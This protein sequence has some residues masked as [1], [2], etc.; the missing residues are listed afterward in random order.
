MKLP[1]QVPGCVS[2]MLQQGSP[3]CPQSFSG[4]SCGFCLQVPLWQVSAELLHDP[5]QQGSP[6]SPQDTHDPDLQIFCDPHELP[7]LFF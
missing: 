3:T 4:G 2:V 1:V 7:S 5:L 6:R